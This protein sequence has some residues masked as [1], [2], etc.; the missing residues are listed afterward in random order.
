MDSL[1]PYML[2]IHVNILLQISRLMKH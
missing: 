1:E 2:M